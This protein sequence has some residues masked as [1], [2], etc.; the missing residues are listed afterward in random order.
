MLDDYSISGKIDWKK[1]KDENTCVLYYPKYYISLKN[2]S[3]ARNNLI[4]YKVGDEITVDV[5]V[6]LKDKPGQEMLL[7]KYW[8]GEYKPETVKK[9]LKVVGIVDYLP[10]NAEFGP[11]NS[12]CFVMDYNNLKKLD[13]DNSLGYSNAT[14]FTKE[15]RAEDVYNAMINK[16]GADKGF[17]VTNMN[18]EKNFAEDGVE[19]YINLE[20]AKYIAFIL[21]C[22]MCILNILNY[23]VINKKKD[24]S[25]FRALG[26]TDGDMKNMIISEG[27]IYAGSATVMSLIIT[28]IR[29]YMIIKDF[30]V[31]YH[32]T[33]ISIDINIIMYLAVFLIYLLICVLGVYIPSRKL[34]KENI[35]EGIKSIN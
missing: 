15:G 1:L 22:I 33:G 17:T 34:L 31:N 4:K 20:S 35:T 26:M 32:I 27:L 7:A 10:V 24:L 13:M 5:P 30:E 12:V 9:K 11:I 8:S 6:S 25:M 18:S 2:K 14:I 16:I 19:N 28:V 29:E 3:D 23:K 21:I